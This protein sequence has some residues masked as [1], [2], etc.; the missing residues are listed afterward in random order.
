MKILQRCCVVFLLLLV[1]IS[2]TN[3]QQND[4]QDIQQK[5]LQLDSA[6]WKSYNECDIAKFATFFTDDLE[7]Y[8]DK[9]GIT[10]GSKEEVTTFKNNLCNTEKDFRLRREAVPGTVKVYPMKSNGQVYG[11]IITGEHVFFI[12]EKGTSR[13]DGQARFTHL[14]V[15]DNGQWKMKRVLSYDH[16]PADFHAKYK[17]ISLSA[18][19]VKR[20]EGTYKGPSTS[21]EAKVQKGKLTFIMNG[22]TFDI[23]PMASHQFFAAERDLTFEF[24]K[25]KLIV[26]ED[27]KIVEEMLKVK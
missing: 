6:F 9:G 17:E 7:F 5:I 18:A 10:L 14:W 8:H 3:A 21:L 27:E 2:P 22:K 25:D 1:G 20:F 26:R 24:V 13:L 23:Y 12:L 16:G 15:L 19:A 4:A 11:A